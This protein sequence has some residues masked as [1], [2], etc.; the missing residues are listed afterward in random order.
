M[1]SLIRTYLRYASRIGWY[2]GRRNYPNEEQFQE[3]LLH[4][5]A[6]FEDDAADVASPAARAAEAATAAP[7]AIP[8]HR[9]ERT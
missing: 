4:G 6:P 2:D 5:V 8:L 7:H 3:L 9:H 1:F